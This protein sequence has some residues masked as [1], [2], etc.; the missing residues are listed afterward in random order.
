[1]EKTPGEFKAAAATAY[2]EMGK[3]R[4]FFG[5]FFTGEIYNITRHLSYIHTF[6]HLT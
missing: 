4:M 3:Q 1:M 2:L 6:M 5:V